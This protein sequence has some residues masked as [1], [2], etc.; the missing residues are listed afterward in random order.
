MKVAIISQDF[1]PMKGG[2]A[3]Y[4]MSIYN[5]YFSKDEVLI[6]LPKD[7]GNE[8]NFKKFKF[9]VFQTNFKPF[10]SKEERLFDSNNMIEKLKEFKPDLILFGYIRSHPE[11]GIHYRDKINLNTKVGIITH[12]K[13]VFFNDF[14]KITSTQ[15]GN[16]LGYSQSEIEQY[17]YILN[18]MDI[19]FTVSNFTK[20]LLEKQGIKN[21]IQ[22]L[23]PPIKT[24]ILNNYSKGLQFNKNDGDFVILSIGRL[25]PRKGHKTVI[26]SIA[27]L[28]KIYSNLKYIIVGNGPE[29]NCLK[30]L[31]LKLKI[32]KNVFIFENVEDSFL[33][34]FYSLADIFILNTSFIPP[35]DVEGLGIVFLEAN[36]FKVP[37]IGGRSGGVVDAIIDGKTGFLIEPN[38]EKDI[39]NK[40]ELLI[41][42]PKI[43]NK[44]GQNGYE[45]VLSEFNENHE[46]L[47]DKFKIK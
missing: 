29:L 44:L 12:A 2:I 45:R 30:E 11:I 36:L 17:K 40:I 16:H 38:N 1:F 10:K 34:Y 41:S 4:L 43:R 15:K 19:V 31:I 9:D 20:K 35:N 37:C 27:K 8:S 5:K 14:E 47:T 24:E 46:N 32:E 6:I 22:I 26:K 18:N 28:A 25:I 21:N 42:N 3:S 13:E 23:N 39:I 33:G 7:I